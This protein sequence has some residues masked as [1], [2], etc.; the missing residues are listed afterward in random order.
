M[1]LVPPTPLPSALWPVCQDV[2]VEVFDMINPDKKLTVYRKD[3]ERVK[4]RD[5]I[6]SML[7]DYK[8]F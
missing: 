4:N 6:I 2:V 7:V 3:L 8:A 5:T 1:D